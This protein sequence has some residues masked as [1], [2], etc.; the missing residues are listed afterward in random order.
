VQER[1]AHAVPLRRRMNQW[2]GT[3][4]E[5]YCFRGRHPARI[6]AVSQQLKAD[7]E[8]TYGID[9]DRITVIYHGVDTEAFHPDVR[10]LHRDA[11]RR[12]LGISSAQFVVLF[13]GGDYERKGLLPLLSAAALLGATV[14]LLA[15]GVRL[16]ARLRNA[17]SGMESGTVTFVDHSDDMSQYYAAADLFALPT[18]YDTFSLAT[19]EAMAS[20]LPVIVTQAAGVAEIL[21]PGRDAFVLESPVSVQAL[22]HTIRRIAQD[23]VLRSNL[24]S[25]ARRTA[26]HFTWDQV[27]RRTFEVYSEVRHDPP[28]RSA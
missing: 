14:H 19:V 9:R 22:A 8:S 23:A 26:E 25:E 12:R 18:F 1:L 17:L 3:L 11:V 24:G 16:D 2:L 28:V 15:V 20:G 5:E 21:S 4:A 6:I 10:N 7:L 27:A 13:V